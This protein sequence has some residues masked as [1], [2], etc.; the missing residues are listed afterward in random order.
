VERTGKSEV[1][2]VNDKASQLRG[3]MVDTKSKPLEAKQ[4]QRIVELLED[5][6]R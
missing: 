4:R 3:A 2:V 1:T 5:W 6:S